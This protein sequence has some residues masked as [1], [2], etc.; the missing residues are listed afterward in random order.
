MLRSGAFHVSL[1]EKGEKYQCFET[2]V[3]HRVK[4]SVIKRH[5]ERIG[6]DIE[7]L[8]M[9]LRKMHEICFDALKYLKRGEE[10][11][12]SRTRERMFT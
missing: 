2:L 10:E 11:K 5:G 12:E 9:N 3:N 7:T 4:M 6:E 1:R 8:K